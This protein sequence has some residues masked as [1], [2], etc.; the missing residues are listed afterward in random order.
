M[1]PVTPDS[2]S[3]IVATQEAQCIPSIASATRDVAG[4]GGGALGSSG[5]ALT[6]GFRRKADFAP[7]PLISNSAGCL[8][9]LP[10]TE[11][12]GSSPPLPPGEGRGEGVTLAEEFLFEPRSSKYFLGSLSNASAQPFAQK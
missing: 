4:S 8:P 10:P 9:P 3:S 12:G 2:A 6:G 11:G 1:T 5:A 7:A